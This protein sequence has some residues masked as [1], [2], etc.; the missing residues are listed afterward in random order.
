MIR[1]LFTAGTGMQAQEFNIDVIANN[2]ANVSTTGYKRTRA[3][4]QDLLYQ[5]LRMPGTEVS[6]GNRVPTGLQLG[7]G[8]KPASTSKLY[9]QGDFQLTN[10]ELDIAIE[11]KGF[12]Q[13][14][15]P[16]GNIAYT[17]AGAFKLDNTGQVVTSDGF[18]MEPP[19]IIPEDAINVS[20][21]S[22]GD[23]S[24]LQPGTTT[25]N[26]VATIELANFINPAGLI[27]VG[28]NFML[29]SEASG[30]PITGTPGTNELGTLQQGF[31]E[32]SNVSIVEELTQMIIAQRA[33]EINSK[34]IQTADEMLQTANNTKR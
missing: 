11:G 2:L 30:T 6:T 32:M 10:N 21:N 19:V 31:L 7:L 17:R 27:S 16:D 18:P 4:F 13:I 28:R 15:K 22:E 9:L 14:L 5:T 34:A 8:V 12:F 23:V 20:I 24:V 26:V 3:D 25:P 1:A 29:E 33:Y